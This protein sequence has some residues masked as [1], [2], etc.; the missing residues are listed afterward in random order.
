MFTDVD[1]KEWYAGVVANA[2]IY[3][4]MKGNSANT[5]NPKG[6]ITL[7]EAITVAA[8]VR[9]IYLTGSDSFVPGAPWYKVYVDYAIS[10]GIIDAS[11]FTD[12]KRAATRAE[13]AYIFS[14]ALPAI[15]YAPQN[16]VNTLPD[17]NNG[18]P[19]AEA[20]RAL[21]RAGIVGGSD[22]AGTFKPSD[23]IKRSEA[24]AIIT[25]VILPATRFKGRTYG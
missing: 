8:R 9:S 22:A 21:Y 1:E 13:M 4:L 23:N 14:R 24:A 17:V 5:F 11:D 18:T 2:Y 16:T 25:R 15:E 3:G 20:I 12:Y 7:A 19:Y 10:K 6:N